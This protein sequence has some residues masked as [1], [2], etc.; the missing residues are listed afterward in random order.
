MDRNALRPHTRAQRPILKSP[1]SIPLRFF[2]AST[3]SGPVDTR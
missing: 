1:L 2:Q 3:K